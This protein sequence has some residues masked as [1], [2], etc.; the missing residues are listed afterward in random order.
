MWAYESMAS[1][2]TERPQRKSK[3]SQLSAY[4]GSGP[5]QSG[6][7]NLQYQQH[8]YVPHSS[9]AS[10]WMVH[11]EKSGPCYQLSEAEVNF[12]H[13]FVN[14]GPVQRKGPENSQRYCDGVE[15]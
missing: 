1:P 5:E 11:F 4:S 9:T 10:D 14:L 2:H 13:L 15:A 3:L 7:A 8:Q 6:A 12:P